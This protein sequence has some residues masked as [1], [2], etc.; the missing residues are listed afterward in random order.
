[1][2]SLHSIKQLVYHFLFLL[3]FVMALFLYKERLL[4]DAAH[5][6]FKAINSAGFYIGNAGLSIG[7]SQ[8][9]PL[10]AYYLGAKLQ[11]LMM[12][13]SINQV[14]IYYLLFLYLYYFLK[15]EAAVLLLFFLLLLGELSY[16]I[17][18]LEIQYGVAFA[19][20]FY[21]SLR[22]GKYENDMHYALLIAWA[23]LVLNSHLINQLLFLFLLL[24]DVLDRTYIKKPHFLLLLMLPVFLLIGLLD[25]H[26]IEKNDLLDS[27]A[28]LGEYLF[29][30]QLILIMKALL[31]HF[32]ELFIS[33]CIIVAL[34][35]YGKKY[36]KAFLILFTFFGVQFMIHFLAH[37]NEMV[38]QTEIWYKSLLAFALVPFVYEVYTVSSTKWRNALFIFFLL[39]FSYRLYLIMELSTNQ[40]Q[41]TLQMQRLISYAQVQEGSKFIFNRE[42]VRKD[43]SFFGSS[44]AEE[45]LLLS[46]MHQKEEAVILIERDDYDKKKNKQKLNKKHFFLNPSEIMADSSLNPNLFQLQSTAYHDVNQAD[47]KYD[48]LLLKDSVK[49][50]LLEEKLNFKQSEKNYLNLHIQ[51][52]SEHKLPSKLK[53]NLRFSYHWYDEKHQ[54]VEWDG[55]RTA[56]EVDV[57]DNYY[58]HIQVLMPSKAGVYYLQPDIV[59][60]GKNWAGMQGKYE[61]LISD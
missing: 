24:W 10:I 31:I 20:V 26:P 3:L 45:S 56:L 41:R 6:F 27:I 18:S 57:M 39:V 51:N 21:S 32:P 50:F 16:F 4:E 23:T 17:P 37:S 55:V 34:M 44:Y 13:S 12:L 40:M 36:K 33:V 22:Q 58:Q 46:S 52:L 43:Y 8:I 14:L 28:N 30:L 35:F 9:L 11:I 60:E 29:H 7:F 1:M 19:I 15:D 38:L 5:Y 53:G 49:L 42:N 47:F 54:V 25:L 61:V 2:I 59:V 48:P